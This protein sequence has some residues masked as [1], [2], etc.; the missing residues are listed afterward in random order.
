MAEEGGRLA[1]LHRVSLRLRITLLTALVVALAVALGG[2]LI[3]VS[4]ESE[5]LG[6]ADDVGK[7]RAQEIAGLAAEGALPSALPEMEDPE[8]PA[9]VVSSG[10]VVTATPG[11]QEPGGLGLSERTAGEI[12]VDEVSQLPLDIPGPYRVV[13]Q[14]VD[15]PKGP[16]T[17]FVAV[18]VHDVEHA[19]SAATRIGAIGLSLLV[20]VLATVMWLA[21]GRALAPVNAIRTRADAISGQS[22]DLRVPTPAQ[23][24]EIGRLART[25]NQM[26]ER[27]QLSA[28]S[29][30]R[31]VA[32]AAHELRSPITSLRVQLETARDHDWAGRR[33]RVSDMLHETARMEGLVDQLLLL[34]RAGADDSWLRL[35]TV[36]LDDI[37]DS[38]V[39]S[40]GSDG[41]VAIDTTAV[42]PVQLSGDA[43]L[44]EQV[45]RN[46]VQNATSYARGSVRVS[47]SVGVGDLAVL[48]VD[49]DGPG[50][51]P[52]RRLDIFERFVRLD[53]SRDRVRGGVGL[54]LA[55]VSEIVHAHRGRIYVVDSPM[56]GA[57]F[58]VE[59]PVARAGAPAGEPQHGN[60][61]TRQA[62]RSGP[63]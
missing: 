2:L 43:A 25:V 31:F 15:T 24:D 8:T 1:W 47:L 17:V 52:D 22:L 55:I 40:P 18:P 34:A 42:E 54:G 30:R 51:P 4:L 32:D 62:G 44:L 3:L 12:D 39:G 14:G 57:R 7:E 41:V 35:S 27:L 11:F 29:Q 5:L 58:V 13:A 33:D 50:V 61:T 10:R 28:E 26:L 23:Q 36:D 6:A 56:G 46:L 48:T 59:L 9:E 49:D 16:V 20:G 63:R 53:D 60:G 37:V 21:I 19:V 38:A 45:V